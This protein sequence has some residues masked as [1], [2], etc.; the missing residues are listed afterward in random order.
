MS[1]SPWSSIVFIHNPLYPCTCRLQLERSAGHCHGT[2]WNSAFS[3][4]HC[5]SKSPL[6]DNSNIGDMAFPS[7]KGEATGCYLEIPSL[8]FVDSGGFSAGSLE[9]Y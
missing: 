1:T 7:V 6:Q 9:K 2:F 3:Y 8:T 4:E 5:R